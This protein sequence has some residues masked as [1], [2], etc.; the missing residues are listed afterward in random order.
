MVSLKVG[1]PEAP[2]AGGMAQKKKLK[3]GN[4]E[5]LSTEYRTTLCLPIDLGLSEVIMGNGV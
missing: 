2:A 1:R 5:Y 4:M 3:S